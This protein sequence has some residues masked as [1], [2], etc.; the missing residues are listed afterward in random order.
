MKNFYRLPYTPSRDIF[1]ISDVLVL[2]SEYEGMPMSVLEALAM[3]C[4]VVSTDVGN[5]RDVLEKTGGGS[6]VTHV[7]DINGLITDVKQVLANPVDVRAIRERL[8]QYYSLEQMAAAYER[9]LLR[10]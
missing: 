4:P 7:G 5:I 2:T 9:A 10:E 8:A 6:A 1:A 3:G